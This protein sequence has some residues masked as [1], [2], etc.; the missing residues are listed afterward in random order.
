MVRISN[1]LKGLTLVSMMS[2]ATMTLQS[3]SDSDNFTAV[4]NADPTLL[5]SQSTILTEPG[6]AFTIEGIAKDADGL[7]S[8]RLV[9]DD[10]YLDKTID[11]LTY[12]PD[13][14]LHEYHLNYGY[15]GDKTWTGTESFPI[16]ITVEDVMGHTFT[17]TATVSTAGDFSAPTFTTAPSPNLTVLLQNPKLTLN[18]TVADNKELGYIKI[19]IPAVH[20]NDSIALTGTSY[21][22]QKAYELPA[23]EAE[24]NMTITIGDKGGNTTSTQS[25]VKVSELPDFSRMYLADVDDVADL[26]SD[27][28][29][30]DY[31]DGLI[32][33]YSTDNWKSGKAIPSK[34][35][36]CLGNFSRFIRPGATRYPV[37]LL[38]EHRQ[39]VQDGETDPRAVMVSAYR[40][41]DGSWVMVA[42]NYSESAQSF[43]IDGIQGK[44]V[45][46]AYRTSDVE[47][48]S[49]K[50]VGTI[51]HST[52]L[53]PKSI[54]TFVAQ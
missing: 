47:G 28:M 52:R 50:P 32:R 43:T 39:I 17:T 36:W 9:N 44:Q 7:K 16:Q 5:L 29:G 11:F 2:V 49:L 18:T 26:S 33:V 22:L 6:R 34:L 53:E 4:D 8:I 25:V 13:S 41:I 38:D 51:S 24:Y 20:V 37:T 48:E 3:C 21:T 35:M 19:S 1:Y 45:W 14:L 15:N 46:K 10:L 42:I 12:Y 54:T 30:S 27:L 31:K 40:N 23:T